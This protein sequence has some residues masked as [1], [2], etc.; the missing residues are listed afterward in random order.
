MEGTGEF[1]S[2]RMTKRQR[3]QTF[4]EEIM[5]DVKVK[6][7]RKRRFAKMQARCHFLFPRHLARL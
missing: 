1:Y 3:K 5:A 2:S 7:E 6:Q 4:T